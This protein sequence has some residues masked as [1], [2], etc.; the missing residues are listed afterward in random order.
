MSREKF[1][2]CKSCR[3]MH[4]VARWPQECIEPYRVAKSILPCPAIRVDGM[5]AIMNHADGMMYDSRSQYERAVK[6]A[7]CVIVGDDIQEPKAPEVLSDNDLA[8]DIKTSIEQV[9]AQL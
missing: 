6:A 7:G 5:D 4:D 1:R 3:S 8:K 9:E 2:I